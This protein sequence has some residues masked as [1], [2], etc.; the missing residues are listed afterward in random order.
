MLKKG[1]GLPGACESLLYGRKLFSEG[2][3]RLVWELHLSNK[4]FLY[5][6]SAV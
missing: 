2:S 1:T 6:M 4:V 3:T 5:A